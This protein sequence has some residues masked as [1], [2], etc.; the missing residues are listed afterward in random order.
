MSDH[1][2]NVTWISSYWMIVYAVA[3]FMLCVAIGAWLDNLVNGSKNYGP[4][5]SLVASYPCM[6]LGLILGSALFIGLSW[7]IDF[8]GLHIGFTS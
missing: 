4:A 7:L 8:C 3:W 6:F 1:Y 5:D 2:D